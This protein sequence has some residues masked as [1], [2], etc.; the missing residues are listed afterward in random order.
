MAGGGGHSVKLQ[1][2]IQGRSLKFS[3]LCHHPG[4]V[5]SLPHRCLSGI[6]TLT[7]PSQAKGQTCGRTG[8]RGCWIWA[9]GQRQGVGGDTS[10]PLLLPRD[11]VPQGLDT[12]SSTGLTT[13]AKLCAQDGPRGLGASASLALL[14]QAEQ[15]GRLCL[16]LLPGGPRRMGAGQLPRQAGWLR[17]PRSQP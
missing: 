5:P 10:V 2:Q 14:P 1:A 15:R 13:A 8:W 9:C 7:G 4:G 11:N 17:S 16:G 3:K 12:L 6:R